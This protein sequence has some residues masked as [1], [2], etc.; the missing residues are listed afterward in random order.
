MLVT[1]QLTVAGGSD[2][3]FQMQTVV[4]A[5]VHFVFKLVDSVKTVVAPALAYLKFRLELPRYFFAFNLAE[6][7]YPVFVL[8]GFLCGAFLHLKEN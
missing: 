7:F 6:H 5:K 1:A 2:V 4:V 8:V 3:E